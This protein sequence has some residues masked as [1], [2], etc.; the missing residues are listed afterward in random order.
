MRGLAVDASRQKLVTQFVLSFFD[1]PGERRPNL[2]L[3]SVTR[4]EV[5]QVVLNTLLELGCFPPHAEL[6]DSDPTMYLGEQIRALED[7]S[8]IVTNI[9]FYDHASSDGSSLRAFATAAEA[10]SHFVRARVPSHML[11]VPID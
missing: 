10:V 1:P 9:E 5:R 6:I 8:Y 2:R 3:D 7:G 11:G 4:D